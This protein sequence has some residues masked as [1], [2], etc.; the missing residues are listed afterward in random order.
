[1]TELKNTLT[2]FLLFA[3]ALAAACGIGYL[4]AHRIWKTRWE[5]R[6]PVEVKTDTLTIRDTV[7][8]PAP[9]PQT[10]TIRDTLKLLTTDTVFVAVTDSTVESVLK[11]STGETAPTVTW[12]PDLMWAGGEPVSV[13]AN[14]VYE[15]SIS[16]DMLTGYT[17]VGCSFNQAGGVVG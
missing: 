6:P 1:M 8:L 13:D 15:F 14:T 9:K 5:N 10:V 12:P 17:I 2:A 16:C 7:R 11:F 3:L 4:S